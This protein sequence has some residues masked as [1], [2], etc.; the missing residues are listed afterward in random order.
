MLFLAAVGGD[1]GGVPALRGQGISRTASDREAQGDTQLLGLYPTRD[2]APTAWE[3]GSPSEFPDGGGPE[4]SS[5]FWGRH[6]RHGIPGRPGGQPAGSVAGHKYFSA[7]HGW[8][9]HGR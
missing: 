6:H 9:N 1:G 5:D 8:W 7:A 4:D 3:R 2:G